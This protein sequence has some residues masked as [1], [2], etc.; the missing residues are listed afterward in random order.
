VPT[1]T[2]VALFMRRSFKMNHYFAWSGDGALN[3][4]LAGSSSSKTQEY[5]YG[6][7]EEEGPEEEIEEHVSLV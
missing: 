4:I 7:E 5:R 2:L 1:L 3:S 6:S